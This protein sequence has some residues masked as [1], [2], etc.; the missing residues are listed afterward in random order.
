MHSTGSAPTN[1]TPHFVCEVIDDWRL[2]FAPRT[3]HVDVAV[4]D[5][6]KF[7]FEKIEVAWVCEGMWIEGFVEGGF[8][9][10]FFA[11]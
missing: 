3:D 6:L 4:F 2:G 5:E 7:F 10:D 1:R 9:D 11:V 8:E